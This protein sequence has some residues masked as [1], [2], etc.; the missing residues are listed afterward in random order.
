[1]PKHKEKKYVISISDAVKTN[2]GIFK[3]ARLESNACNIIVDD[4]DEYQ[5]R[6]CDQKMLLENGTSTKNGENKAILP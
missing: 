2:G 4:L 5:D 6:T 1:M 3:F